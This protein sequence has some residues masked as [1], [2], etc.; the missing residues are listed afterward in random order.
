[1]VGSVSRQGVCTP[2]VQLSLYTQPASKHCL[3][4]TII[5]HSF[6]HISSASRNLQ[7]ASQFFLYDVEDI[8][9]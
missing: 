7:F 2:T 1:M 4:S 3:L 5:P 6:T 9:N 8:R